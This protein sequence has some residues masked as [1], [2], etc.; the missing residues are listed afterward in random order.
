[1]EYAIV[2]LKRYK[3]EY[4]SI[5][6]ALEDLVSSGAYRTSEELNVVESAITQ[7]RE[8]ISDIEKAIQA[9][10]AQFDKFAKQ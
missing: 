2:L 9:L 1:M 3:E 4:E 6:K 5:L 7:Y 10:N 8:R